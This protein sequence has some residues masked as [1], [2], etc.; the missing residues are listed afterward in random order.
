VI[1]LPP[2]APGR[3]PTDAEP[4]V[5]VADCAGHRAPGVTALDRDGAATAVPE[6]LEQQA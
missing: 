1:D 2:G 3:P 6:L 5:K 4:A